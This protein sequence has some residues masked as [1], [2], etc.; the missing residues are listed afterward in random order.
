MLVTRKQLAAA[1]ELSLK[2]VDIHR[3]KG[4]F[5][6]VT[7][8]PLRFDLEDCQRAYA[9]FRSEIEATDESSEELKESQLRRWMA[10]IDL[11]SQK[12]QRLLETTIP[13]DTAERLYTEASRTVSDRLTAW[14]GEVVDRLA[15][16]EDRVDLYDVVNDSCLSLIDEIG[17]I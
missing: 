11:S 10:R 1:V 3:L 14:A 4:T 15:G 7:E 16:L 12:L 8:T 9:E 5:K 2:Q 13:A 17:A 6:A